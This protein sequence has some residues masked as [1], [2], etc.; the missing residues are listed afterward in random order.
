MDPSFLLDRKEWERIA[1]LNDRINISNYIFV[2]LLEPKDYQIEMIKKYACSSGK[3]VIIAIVN[4]YYEYDD[5]AVV[6]NQFDFLNYIRK[7]SLIITDSF[8]GLV[9][10]LIF[11]KSF[12]LFKRFKDNDKDSQN[13]RLDDLLSNF[14][15]MKDVYIN[16]DFRDEFLLDYSKINN[17]IHD[18]SLQSR[19]FL[20]SSIDQII[21]E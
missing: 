4:P 13:S 1:D 6:V 14:Q 3:K 9:F 5:C 17:I 21:K 15:V 2:Y 12:R 18:K 10:S 20:D 16:D 8:H 7:S 19:E 11:N